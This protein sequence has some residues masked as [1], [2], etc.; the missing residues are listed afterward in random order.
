MERTQKNER[1]TTVQKRESARAKSFDAVAMVRNVRD[2]HA[3]E[4]Q[5]RSAAERIA[6]FKERARRVHDGIDRESQT[7]GP[8]E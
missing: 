4:L 7:A 8:H 3:A 5:G 6:F 1:Q 2:Q